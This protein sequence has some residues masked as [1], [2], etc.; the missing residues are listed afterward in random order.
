[1][2]RPRRMVVDAAGQGTAGSFLPDALPMAEIS[3]LLE[4]N[5]VLA[6]A[7]DR[8]LDPAWIE[9]PGRVA[10]PARSA[11]DGYCCLGQIE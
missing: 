8:F 11:V 10:G 2:P 6:V 9:L 1:M 3:E 5:T 4:E 7:T